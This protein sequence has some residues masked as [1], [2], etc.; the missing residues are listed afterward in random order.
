M[1]FLLV[2]LYLCMAVPVVA[3]RVIRKGS[4]PQYTTTPAPKILYKFSDFDGRWQEVERISPTGKKLSFS[5]TLLLFFTG[6]KVYSKDASS[7]RMSMVYEV[8]LAAP[9]W[10]II[11]SDE[12]RVL[13]LNGKQLLLE[14]ENYKRKFSK[15]KVFYYETVGKDSIK[16]EVPSIPLHINPAILKGKWIVY[17]ASAEP[18]SIPLQTQLIRSLELKMES[19]SVNATGVVGYH[20]QGEQFSEV[21]KFNFEGL[22]MGIQSEGLNIHYQIYKADGNEFIFGELPTL[23]FYAKKVA[24]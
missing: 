14:D 16:Q 20:R 1:R 24:D 18:G 6:N 19:D 8:E 21:A 15:R 23:L 3:Q 22:G 5:D 11:G 9:N 7:M 13:Q 4:T 2:I 17:R 12:Y 10:L